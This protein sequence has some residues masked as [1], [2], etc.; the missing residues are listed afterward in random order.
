M[1]FRLIPLLKANGRKYKYSY[2]WI[3]RV[4]NDEKKGDSGR[5][6]NQ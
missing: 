2:F 4:R 1:V 6:T 3:T 5:G